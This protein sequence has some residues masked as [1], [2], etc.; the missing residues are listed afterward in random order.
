MLI[1]LKEV[2]LKPVQVAYLTGPS[3]ICDILKDKDSKVQEVP[4]AAPPGN[5]LYDNAE[6]PLGNLRP[7][8]GNIINGTIGSISV[9][10]R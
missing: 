6:L 10:K 2:P 3:P 4:D 7:E 8:L 1:T 9:R 5:I